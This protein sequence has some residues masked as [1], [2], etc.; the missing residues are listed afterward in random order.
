MKIIPHDQATGKPLS[1]SFRL[2]LPRRG[3]FHGIG[4]FGGFYGD[5]GLLEQSETWR[6]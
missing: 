5:R 6:A 2:R 4:K 1:L 3:A